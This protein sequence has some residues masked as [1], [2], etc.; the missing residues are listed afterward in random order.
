MTVKFVWFGK[1]PTGADVEFQVDSVGD[2]ENA[3]IVDAAIK[4]AGF[5]PSPRFAPPTYGG[6][7][8][9]NQ[10]P[11]TPAPTGIIRPDHCGVPMKY[12]VYKKDGAKGFPDRGVDAGKADMW[13]CSKDKQCEDVT[14]GKS[15][16]AHANF[17]MKKAP[18]SDRAPLAE[19]VNGDT[20]KPMGLGTFLNAALGELKYTKPQIL[21]FAQLSEEELQSL[22]AEGW[23]DLLS[24]LRAEKA[25]EAKA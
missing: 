16:R 20:N 21:R 3:K 22:G 6:G 24:K 14:S 4:A 15:D 19:R 11:E 2:A 17:D 1:S 10:R 18:A 8:R 7:G 23:E 12:V 25:S 9:G 13:V 5:L